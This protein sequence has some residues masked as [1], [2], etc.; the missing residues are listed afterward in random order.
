MPRSP[1]AV[2]FWRGC[3]L[4]TISIDHVPG[5]HY[6]DYT[7]HNFA[8]SDASEVFVFLAGWAMRLVADSRTARA[9]PAAAHWKVLRR[10]G[11]LYVAQIIISLLALALTILAANLLNA[12][13]IYD[14][15]GAAP[16][17]NSPL[18]GLIGIF[19]LFTQLGYF[20]ILPLYVI[21]MMMAPVFT[22][23]Y[24]AKPV[25]LLPV[26]LALYVVVLTFS[27][28]LPT[29]PEEG[30]WFFDP[31]SWQFIFVLGFLLG[32]NTGLGGWARRHIKPLFWLSLPLL[33]IGLYV[34][35]YNIRINPI[36]VPSPKLFFIFDKTFL[37][38]A[39]IISMLA[40]A[41]AVAR[42]FPF[43]YR[44]LKWPVEIMSKLGRNSLNVFCVGS[45]VSLIGQ[46]YRYG[47]GGGWIND[48]FIVGITLLILWITAWFTEWHSQRP[49]LT[50][51]LSSA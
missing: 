14:W 20:N 10:S 40:L 36:N 7:L 8:F 21:L 33:A 16:V 46:F 45:L 38:P 48:T 23:I 22:M 28:N 50:A 49:H 15:N 41:A 32:G 19:T 9:N 4:V 27:L 31:F 11:E 12:P 30:R 17:F 6:V 43:I 24:R 42:V 37:S 47:V 39:R 35:V 34:N 25:L 5:N 51:P 2:D 29:W 1:N 44:M 18:L 26:S 13:F 3:A